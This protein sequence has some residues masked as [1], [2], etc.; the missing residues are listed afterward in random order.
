[1]QARPISRLIFHLTATSGENVQENQKDSFIT[2]SMRWIER[3]QVKQTFSQEGLG[4]KR[5]LTKRLD[6]LA[7]YSLAL[8]KFTIV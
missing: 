2:Y 8:R 4:E 7:G 1:M 6:G 5:R 3:K